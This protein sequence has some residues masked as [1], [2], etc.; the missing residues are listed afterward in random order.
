MVSMA[1]W[2]A[3]L[4]EEQSRDFG[5]EA[6]AEVSVEQKQDEE[7]MPNQSSRDMLVRVAVSGH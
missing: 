3:E 7:P 6:G 1:A 2:G 4:P 5:N